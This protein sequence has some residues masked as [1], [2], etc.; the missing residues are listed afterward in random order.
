MV[1]AGARQLHQRVH[2]S[3]LRRAHCSELHKIT[4]LAPR[5]LTYGKRTNKREHRLT[6]NTSK[7]ML[8]SRQMAAI[9][10]RGG[11]FSTSPMVD[12]VPGTETVGAN[13]TINAQV[14]L[15]GSDGN[16]YLKT[17]NG[18]FSSLTPDSWSL[19][20]AKGEMSQAFLGRSQLPNGQWFG[21]S[22]GVDFRFFP[23]TNNVPLWRGYPIYTP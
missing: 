15:L 5:G 10:R 21:S 7:Q 18:G 6:L 20:Q 17:N 4:E 19:A 3:M 13:V 1:E 16:F 12:I 23:P 14:K 11:H 22:S 9:R 8:S 2:S